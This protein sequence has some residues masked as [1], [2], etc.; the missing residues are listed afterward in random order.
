[1]ANNTEAEYK[2]VI[3]ECKD[4]FEL[5]MKDYGLAWRI[6]RLSSL[7]DQIF[8]KAKRIRSIQ[9]KN[10][11]LVEDGIRDEFIGILN[12]SVMALVQLELGVAEEADIDASLAVEKF[13]KYTL[14]AFE[15]MNKKNHD[16]GEAWRDMRVE[17]I[18]DIILMKLLR[19][20]E[21]ENNG[22]KTLVSEGLSANYLDIINYAVFAL[23]KTL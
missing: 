14:G 19:I 4:L 20:K 10:C 9:M 1:M 17:S 22:G 11:H 15:L 23:I 18:T 3:K 2:N 5:K 12:Y 13:D 21:I 16:Y 8:I 7:T 6:L